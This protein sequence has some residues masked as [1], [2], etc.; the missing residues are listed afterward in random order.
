MATLQAQ[1]DEMQAQMAAYTQP[2]SFD[3]SNRGRIEMI[4]ACRAKTSAANTV[5]NSKSRQQ[6]ASESMTNPSEY[7]PLDETIEDSLTLHPE[8]SGED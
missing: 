4:K 1:M 5:S 3:S 8:H 7:V 6:I 2:K